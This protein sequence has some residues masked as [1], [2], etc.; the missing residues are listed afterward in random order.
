VKPEYIPKEIERDGVKGVVELLK[1][2]RFRAL[3]L[4]LEMVGIGLLGLVFWQS[5]NIMYEGIAQS[6]V[7]VKVASEMA[8]LKKGLTD[9]QA[10]A[11]TASA[12]ADQSLSIQN[13]ILD[14]LME[15]HTELRAVQVS[16]A[17]SGA[18]TD[19]QIIDL[20]SRLTRIE[21]K[22]DAGPR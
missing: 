10:A 11:T 4:L 17:Q 21:A 2:G 3:V 13:K 22:Q 20:A 12:K 8:E 6:P 16:I 14:S 1:T 19:T 5:K 18:R 9:A 7:I 15:T